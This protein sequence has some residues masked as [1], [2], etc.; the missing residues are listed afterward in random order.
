MLL[1]KLNLEKKELEMYEFINETYPELKHTYLQV[2]SSARFMI[3]ERMVNALLREGFIKS[4]EIDHQLSQSKKVVLTFSKGKMIIPIERK[5]SYNRFELAKNISFMDNEF[6]TSEIYHPIH[7]IELIVEY[8]QD[9]GMTHTNLHGFQSELA[10]SVANMGLGLL[11]QKTKHQDLKIMCEQQSWGSSMELVDGLA[12]VD[13]LFDRSLFFEQL[14]VTGHQLHPCTKSKMGLSTEEIIQFSSEFDQ[15][16][17]L[18]FVAIHKEVAYHNPSIDL[19]QVNTF[20]YKEYP[21]L[22]DRFYTSCLEKEVDPNQYIILPVHPWQKKQVL[23]TL[24]G[25]ELETRDIIIIENFTLQTK[26]TLSVRTVAPIAEEKK[27]H[28]KLPLNIQ[29]TSAVR[30]ISPNSVHNGPELTKILKKI[31]KKENYFNGKL[32]I[33]GEDI[34]VRFHSTIEKD[35]YSYHRNKNLAVLMRSNPESIIKEN[36]QAVVACALYNLSPVTN[37]LLV[38][39]IIENYHVRY[40]SNSLT[41]NVKAFF[42][43][44]ID[45]VLSGVIPLMTQYG[46]GLEGHLQNTLIVFKDYEPIQAIIRDLGGVRVYQERLEKQGIYGSYYPNSVTIGDN[47]VEMQN[48]V[49]H[50]VFQSQLGELTYQVAKQ[51]NMDE[52]QLWEIMRAKCIEIFSNLKKQEN[53]K[54][55]VAIDME[56]LLGP[57]VETKALTVMRLKDDVTDYAYIKVPNPLYKS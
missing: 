39:E 5:Y 8:M 48:K 3:M 47:V 52:Q 38:Y 24:Y 7:L 31:L 43:K 6:G 49:I 53:L 34:G 40:L 13:A 14:C 37:Q 36:E 42:K 44:Y 55:D 15:V 51:Y 2:V 17:S 18:H 32:N 41:E 56:T 30:T 27:F 19:S 22:H 20:W 54:S 35:N 29:M 9:Q 45:V 28:F 11:F 10:N 16:V 1:T 4:E 33:I 57:T 25:N 26:P 23:P 21:E 12:G 50:T 46:I